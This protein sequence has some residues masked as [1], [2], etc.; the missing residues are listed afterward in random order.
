MHAKGN[1]VCRMCQDADVD[2]APKG[3]LRPSRNTINKTWQRVE[4]GNNS[5]NTSNK[6][7]KSVSAAGGQCQK[8]KKKEKME[9][10]QKQK[11]QKRQLLHMRDTLQTMVEHRLARM[12]RGSGA[13]FAV[14]NSTPL[15]IV[16]V[17]FA[18]PAA[19][20]TFLGAA[21]SG[22]PPRINSIYYCH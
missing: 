5:G 10:Q 11:G 2:V 6:R 16:W 22:A 19:A 21:G 13:A 12:R 9:P 8:N 14:N 3:I 7:Q 15:A 17:L 18:V 4:H 20:S 1:A